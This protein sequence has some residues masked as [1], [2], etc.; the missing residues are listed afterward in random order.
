MLN[1]ITFDLVALA[2]A[3]LPAVL[4][5]WWQYAGFGHISRYFPAARISGLCAA[6]GHRDR[7]LALLVM[8]LPSAG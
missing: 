6:A 8:A 2:P 1:W 3:F 5:R 7:R 4:D